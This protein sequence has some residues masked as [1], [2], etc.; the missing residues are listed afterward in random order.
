VHCRDRQ[1][2]DRQPPGVGRRLCAC[3][4]DAL[5]QLLL[6]TP[7]QAVRLRSCGA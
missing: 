4:A 7:P 5:S 6:S 2:H 3:T 1:R